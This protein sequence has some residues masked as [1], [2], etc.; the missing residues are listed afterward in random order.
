M[1][2]LRRVF[3]AGVLTLSLMTVCYG[4]TITG[5]RT[6]AS[7]ARTGTITGSRTGTITGSRVG[8]ITGSRSGTITGSR[9]NTVPESNSTIIINVQGEFISRVLILLLGW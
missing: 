5:S 6:G 7:G 1:N 4:G 9:V 3:T 8:T 2:H